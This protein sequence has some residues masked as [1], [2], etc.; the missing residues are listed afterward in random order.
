MPIALRRNL[1]AHQ[2]T[3]HT[4]ETSSVFRDFSEV[5]LGESHADLSPN[6]YNPDQTKALGAR[7]RLRP[8][9]DGELHAVSLNFSADQ[10]E[11]L[12]DSV[13]DVQPVLPRR[14]FPDHG[15]YPADDLA[16]SLA[17]TNL[18]GMRKGLAI[19]TSIRC[20]YGS[21]AG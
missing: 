10:F 12:H 14:R 2:Q 1:S 7:N 17:V 18:A 21:S 20:A 16:G 4:K 6:D 11:D 15:P 5:Y 8:S 13:V 9:V 3:A 19:G